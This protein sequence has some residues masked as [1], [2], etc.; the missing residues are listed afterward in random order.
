MAVLG[1]FRPR[2]GSN[3]KQGRLS[4]AEE[5]KGMGSPGTCL[6][7]LGGAMALVFTWEQTWESME[8]GSRSPELGSGPSLVY[9]LC[10]LQQAPSPPWHPDS[11]L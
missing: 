7:L 8:C 5:G 2:Y 9:L 3:P 1:H 10:G 11:Q 4:E 6:I